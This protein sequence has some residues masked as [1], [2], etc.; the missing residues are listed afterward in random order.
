MSEDTKDLLATRWSL[1]VR[2]K[3][4]QDQASWQ[5]FFD[6]YWRLIYAVAVKA[7]LSDA[8]AQDVV[9]DTLLS[10]ARKIPELKCSRTPLSSAALLSYAG[11]R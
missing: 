8:E 9:Q 4:W 6:L 1:L 2:L 5:E 7:G 3:D 10:V 11:G